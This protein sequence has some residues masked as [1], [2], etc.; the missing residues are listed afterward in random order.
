MNLPRIIIAGTHSGV[1]KTTLTLGITSALK[2]RG[3]NVQAFKAGPDYI[4]PAYHSQASGKLCG[5]LDSWLLSKD[6]LRE[7]FARRAEPAEIS[8]IEGVMGLYDG[9]KDS[10]QGSTAHLAKILNSPV[11]LILNA[12]SLSRSAAAIAL[13]YKKFDPGVDIAGIILNNIASKRHYNYIKSAIERKTRI[14]VLGYLP[15]DHHLKISERHLGLVPVTEKKVIGAF[16]GIL[17][18][19]VSANINLTKLL[20]IARQ[21][22]PLPHSREIIFKKE[23]PKG[24]VTIAIAKDKAFHFYYQ[25]N[26]D[27]LKHLGA[28][29]VTFSPLRDRELPKGIDGLYIGGGFPEVFASDL[30][31]NASLRQSIYQKAK[32][33]LPIYAECGGLMYLVKNLIDFQKRKFPMVG[34]FKCSVNMGNRLHRMGYVNVQVIK[35]NIL[36]NQGD[37]NRAHLFHWSRLTNI[38]KNSTFAYRIIK[39]KDNL[40][41]DGLV[42]K[43]VLASYAHLHFASNTDFAKNFINSCR[44]NR[45]SAHFFSVR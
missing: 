19:S 11:I 18:K 5:N 15:G 33:G 2:K 34:V 25:D 9:L 22:K 27:I 10:E 30:S 40:F 1:G 4:D 31:K 38:P 17:A 32:D 44:I 21:A 41:Y 3:V 28:E 37:R 42:T 13:G 24:R 35:D 29:I 23:L 36:S 14:P 20:A 7:L 12:R 26:L 39:D 6:V 16:R 8:I 43:N 45:D